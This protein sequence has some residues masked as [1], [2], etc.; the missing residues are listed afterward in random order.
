MKS[1][2]KLLKKVG[3]LQVYY[4]ANKKVSVTKE[5]FSDWFNK[6]FVAA[7]VHRLDWKEIAKFYYF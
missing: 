3:S 5:V 4:Y 2:S 7:A 6:H 1:T